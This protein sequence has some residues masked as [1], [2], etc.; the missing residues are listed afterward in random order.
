MNNPSDL[1]GLTAEVREAVETMDARNTVNGCWNTFRAEL[2]R[3][4][5][6][7]EELLEH[8]ATLRILYE[9]AASEGDA[10]RAELAALKQ[11]IK[12][13]PKV[14]PRAKLGDVAY[15]P[16]SYDLNGKRVALVVVTDTGTA[17]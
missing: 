5:S 1:A 11:R 4:A 14:T 9:S 3:M 17:A 8:Q 10:A 6:E 12:D 2:L 15:I 16:V 7:N 13:A